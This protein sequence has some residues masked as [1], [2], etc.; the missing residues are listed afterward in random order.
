MR[1][2][3]LWKKSF[4]ISLITGKRGSDN[5][6]IRLSVKTN[7]EGICTAIPHSSLLIPHYSSTPRSNRVLSGILGGVQ[8]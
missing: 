1:N 8:G 4:R 7:S 5:D 3:E 6:R 2:E